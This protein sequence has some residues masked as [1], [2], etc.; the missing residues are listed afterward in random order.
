[1]NLSAASTQYY[2]YILNI[3]GGSNNKLLT[4]LITITV[5]IISYPL[6]YLYQYRSSIKQ[7]VKEIEKNVK[8]VKVVRNKNANINNRRVTCDRGVDCERISHRIL[9]V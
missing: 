3:E 2:T 6:Y 5:G 9:D 4:I 1:M 8:L 7:R